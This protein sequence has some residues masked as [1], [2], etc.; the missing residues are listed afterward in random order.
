MP[1]EH[2]TKERYNRRPVRIDFIFFGG[3]GD[4]LRRVRHFAFGQALFQIQAAESAVSGGVGR[5]RDL[6]SFVKVASQS[7]KG[8][9][10]LGPELAGLGDIVLN[11]DGLG[12]GVFRY[13][14][15]SLL[16]LWVRSRCCSTLG[17]LRL[18]AALIGCS[19]DIM[20]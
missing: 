11:F 20:S 19:V 16:R 8:T 9:P 12:L 10:G 7:P 18:M 13:A 3:W 6:T 2:K 15:L 5:N 17:A 4:Q 1:H 14:P